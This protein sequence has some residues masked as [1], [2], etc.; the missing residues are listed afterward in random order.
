MRDFFLYMYTNKLYMR[1][2]RERSECVRGRGETERRVREKER[3]RERLREE[4]VYVDG[5]TCRCPPTN[6][7]SRI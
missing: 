3:Q 4:C 7:S 1:R 5:I 6:I 2:D